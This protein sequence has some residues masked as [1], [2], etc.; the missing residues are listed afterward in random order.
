LVSVFRQQVLVGSHHRFAMFERAQH[1][2]ASGFGAAHGLDDQI[3]PRVPDDLLP[4]LYI[5]NARRQRRGGNRRTGADGDDP[6]SPTR[7][8]LDL[9]SVGLKAGNRGLAHVSKADDSDANGFH[10]FA[11]CTRLVEAAGFMVSHAP[12]LSISVKISSASRPRALR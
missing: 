5:A 2:L 3:H 11:P 7:A 4:I 9:L 10:R 1:D 8:L 12:R 6:P